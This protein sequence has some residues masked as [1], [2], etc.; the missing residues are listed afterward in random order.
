MSAEPDYAAATACLRY[1]SDEDTPGIR[2]ARQGGGFVYRAPNGRA[3]PR[4]ISSSHCVR[5]IT[6]K[7]TQ[8]CEE[9]S[10]IEGHAA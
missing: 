1:V 8:G 4:K 6:S 9:A 10:E 7:D 2:R 5:R 3:V